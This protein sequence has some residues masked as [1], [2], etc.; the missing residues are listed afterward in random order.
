M[1]IVGAVFHLSDD[2]TLREAALR[3]LGADPR[4]TLGE[5]LG[6][7]LPVVVETASQAEDD[8]FWEGLEGQP[9]IDQIV[10]AF[11]DITDASGAL[12]HAA[13]V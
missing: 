3:Y 11:A 8:R 1:P 12:D 10:V 9:G 6:P 2:P 4:V 7:N 13:E 5:L